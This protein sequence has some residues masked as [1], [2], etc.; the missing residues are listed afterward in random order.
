MTLAT[1][2]NFKLQLGNAA[3]PEVFAD[4][5]EVLAVTGF[6]KSNNLLDVTNFDSPAGTMEYIA[7]LADGAEMN[8]SAN[9]VN[10]T[11]QLALKSA[12]DAQ[13]T[14]NFRIVNSNQSPAE[15]FS[16]AAVCKDW[17]IEPSATD[18]NQISYVLKIT[19]DIT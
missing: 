14:R 17:N 11:Q 16:F 18:Q 15:Q 7:G 8:I 9:Y 3:S 6:G 5:E 1:I 4:I 19:G 13:A 10:G 2:S 12:V